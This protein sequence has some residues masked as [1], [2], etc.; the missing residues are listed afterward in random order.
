MMGSMGDVLMTRCHGNAR[1]RRVHARLTP[2]DFQDV[3]STYSVV[4]DPTC[5]ST[6]YGRD[7]WVDVP[8]KVPPDSSTSCDTHV[9]R[10]VVSPRVSLGLTWPWYQNRATKT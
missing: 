10:R 7:V 2:D 5:G 1:V 6:C 4:N 9:V 8:A 3:L